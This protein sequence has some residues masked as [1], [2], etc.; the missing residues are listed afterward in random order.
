M[1]PSGRTYAAAGSNIAPQLIAQGLQHALAVPCGA[2]KR[3]MVCLKQGAAEPL[4]QMRVQMP[5]MTQL[6]R[7]IEY[8]ACCLVVGMLLEVVHQ[9]VHVHVAVVTAR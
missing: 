7:L 6:V 3:G 4:T 5:H 1:S 2:S 9:A 8:S